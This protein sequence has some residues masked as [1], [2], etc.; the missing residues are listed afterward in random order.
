MLDHMDNEPP[1]AAA[2]A[3]A[4][5]AAAAAAQP[6]VTPTHDGRRPAA[7][8]SSSSATA[9]A[10][11]L[12]RHG[13]AVAA[14][15]RGRQQFPSWETESV[16]LGAGG[17][18]NPNLGPARSRREKAASPQFRFRGHDGSV[19]GGEEAGDAGDA[20]RGGGSGGRR[21]GSAV[22]FSLA[23]DQSP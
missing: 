10:T 17:V 11:G 15:T 1:P 13:S 16:G 20:P 3:G 19:S 8:D 23:M 18:T 2:L 7:R 12:N 14:T 9:P 6:V 5:A 22:S 21:G 4:A